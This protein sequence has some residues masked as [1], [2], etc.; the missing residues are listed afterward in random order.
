MRPLQCPTLHRNFADLELLRGRLRQEGELE[1]LAKLAKCQT[2]FEL[3]CAHCGTRKTVTNRCKRK[4][5]PC[6]AT[7]L[8]AQRSQELGYIV[9][10]FR[11]PLFVTLTIRNVETIGRAE[12]KFLKASFSKLRHRKIWKQ[13][14]SAGVAAVEVTNIGNGWHPHLHVVCDCNWLAVKTPH[15]STG[16]TKEEKAALCTSAAQELE[17][18]WSKIVKQSTSSIMIKRCNSKTIAKEVVKYTVKNED[19]VECE[20]SAGDLIRAIDSGHIMST[21]GNAHGHCVK[22]IRLEA[23][24]RAREQ[25]RTDA[26]L[27]NEI[28]CCSEPDLMPSD[29]FD[30]LVRR[31][32]A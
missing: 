25:R 7:L 28:E 18:I 29:A 15:I 22:D 2:P 12:I 8:A 1:L 6:C 26:E 20:G 10:R 11:W 32:F 9:E 23:R 31:N 19:L 3:T 16:R 13:R 14:V 30:Y 24:S 17:A 5:C 27:N 4:W 21:F